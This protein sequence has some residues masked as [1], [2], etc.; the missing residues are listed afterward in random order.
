MDL[1][2]LLQQVTPAQLMTLAGFIA[3][4][5]LIGALGVAQRRL[6][7][8]PIARHENELAALREK[9]DRAERLLAMDR[10]I[11]VAW[12]GPGEEANISGDLSFIGASFDPNRVLDFQSW[13]PPAT[14]K[15][16]AELAAQLLK[17]G[18]SFRLSARSLADR[19]LDIEGRPVLGC[20][21][22]RI[23][24]LEGEAKE[25]S[26]QKGLHVSAAEHL[27]A[28]RELLDAVPNPVWVRDRF[29]KLSWANAAYACAVEAKDGPS[30]VLHGIEL[31]E[32]KT[33]AACAAAR[34]DGKVWRSRAPAVVAGARRMLDII[35]A[36][37]GTGSAGMATDLSEIET[38][39]SELAQQTAA[40]GRTLDQLSTAVAIFDGSKR[41][42][43]NNV[44]YRQL[45][46]LDQ[47]WLDEKPCDGEI[48]DHL[49]AA[50][51]L[52]EQADFRAWKAGLLAAYQSLDTDEQNWYLP[53]GRILRAVINPNP[54]GGLTY[55]FDDVTERNRLASQYNAS[56]RVQSETLDALK[57]G[58]AVFASDG[59]LKLF[60]PAF[61]SLW[62]LGE[63]ALDGQPHIDRVA[64]ICAPLF[65]DEETWSVL[66]AA[67]AGMPDQRVGIERRLA[68]SDGT[69]LDCTAAPLPDGA[70]LLTFTDMTASVDV[71]RA[72]KE[73]NQALMDMESLRSD[74]IHHISYELRSPLTNI[75]GF[76]QFLADPA[77]GPLNEK[78]RDYIGYVMKSASALLAIINNILD[79]A[80]IDADAMELALEE[81][82]IA[83]TIA[84]AA[85][86]VQDR[87]AESSLTL[88]ISAA[89]AIGTFA[90]DGKRI[91]Q[92][93][94][95]LL[96]NA[97]GSS[98]PGQSIELGA[99]R[100]NSEV[101]FSV[102]AAGDGIAPEVLSDALE[103]AKKERGGLRRHGA[104]L[105]LS[106]VRSFVELH[107]GRVEIERLPDKGARVTCILPAP[108]E[109]ADASE[110]LQGAQ[111]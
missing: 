71:E 22:L 68:R 48:L 40:H 41:L 62:A 6:S 27:Q 67:V 20:A 98:L 81:V 60:N 99:W 58:V 93:L 15:S 75:I 56:I 18:E 1:T 50:R 111:G 54:Q 57:E 28:L 88:H 66:R 82:D 85:E 77:T 89:E 70:T 92:I 16:L 79:L 90:A 103:G 110:E 73:R 24:D 13:L 10:H 9:L 108:G 14:A 80:T 45:F 84:A 101:L 59:R 47:A 109:N 95:N 55:L 38:L 106:I 49:R 2:T 104:G 64:E 36:P 94:Y 5:G 21:V 25:A 91:R 26:R 11:A 78:Q 44:A 76:I 96:S 65:R 86:G 33:R 34:A 12:G 30:A 32:G 23:K 63:G 4:L 69:V 100:Q 43:F 87:L 72:L 35:D 107:G 42:V 29:G 51:L 19:Y 97:I 61:A 102:T 74:F 46:A 7:L 8:R 3:L 53:D 83:Q 17:R 39:R 52:P 37:A 31:I 105:S